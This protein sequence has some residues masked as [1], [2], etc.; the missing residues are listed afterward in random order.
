MTYERLAASEQLTDERLSIFE[1]NKI[2]VACAPIGALTDDTGNLWCCDWCLQR[3][4]EQRKG[5][6]YDRNGADFLCV[7]TVVRPALIAVHTS[8]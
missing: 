3:Y 6:A 8:L 5:T 2:K 1:P 7:A 4:T